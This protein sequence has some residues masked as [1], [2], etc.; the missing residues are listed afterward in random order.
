[1]GPEGRGRKILRIFRNDAEFS[2]FYRNPGPARNSTRST[3]FPP[4][5]I[6]DNGA[7]ILE[8]LCKRRASQFR[9][10]VFN[11]LVSVHLERDLMNGTT[12]LQTR[13]YL[14]D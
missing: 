11:K 1:M 6:G 4:D 2:P 9:L 12:S 3:S 14:V 8:K 7:G 5:M 10:S 13:P